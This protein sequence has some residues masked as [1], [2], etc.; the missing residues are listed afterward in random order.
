MFHKIIYFLVFYLIFI[1][2]FTPFF[3]HQQIR[4]AMFMVIIICINLGKWKTDLISNQSYPHDIDPKHSK[5]KTRII[6]FFLIYGFFILPF[7]VLGLYRAA[8][9]ESGTALVHGSYIDHARNYSFQLGKHLDKNLTT[10]DSRELLKVLR[11]ASPFEILLAALEVR[12]FSVEENLPY[13]V[14]L[15]NKL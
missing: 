1:A 3:V 13:D 9:M 15:I 10:N 12:L 5:F 6:F 4:K 7:V 14:I 2:I 8:I 11:K